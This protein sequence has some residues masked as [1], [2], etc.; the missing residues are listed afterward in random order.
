MSG[1]REPQRRGKA[2]AVIALARKLAG[3]VF[4]V[5]RDGIE[6]DPQLPRASGSELAVTRDIERLTSASLEHGRASAANG[7]AL[8]V[9]TKE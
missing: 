3:I 8:R 6:F 1:G 9:P 4:A 5:W 7:L 2:M